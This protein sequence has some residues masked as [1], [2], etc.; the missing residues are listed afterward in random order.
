MRQQRC[1]AFSEFIQYEL[2]TGQFG[3]NRVICGHRI[4]CRSDRPADDEMA[5]A[6]RLRL[7]PRPGNRGE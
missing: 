3:L 7:G 6:G 5:G 1:P 2:C 4:D